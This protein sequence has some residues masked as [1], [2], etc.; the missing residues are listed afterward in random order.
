[1]KHTVTLRNGDQVPALGIGT[2]YLG[3]DRTKRKQELESLKE[4]V[5]A[6]MTLIDT[7]E[8]YGSGK[9]ELLVKEAMRDILKEMKREELYLVSKVLPNHAGKD[10]IETALD[11][12]LMRM[13]VEQLDLYLYHWRGSYPLEETVAEFER[14]KK[15]GKI[16]EWGVSNFDIDDMEELW[17]TPGGQ[18]C[19][20][21]QVLYHTG[22]R[23]IEYSLLPWMRE[24]EVALMSYCPLA[25]AGTLKRGLMTHP[26]LV[27][28]AEKYNAT[29]EQIMLAWNIRDGYTIAIPRS[30]KAEHTLQN[31]GA[32]LIT[33]SEEDYQA[34]DRAFPKPVRKEYL[35]MQ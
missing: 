33:L 22:S 23:G 28:L 19:L 18:N 30:G 10:R 13:G 29:V 12:T 17:E 8:M 5:H 32:D 20:V 7:A 26:V 6:G 15:A 35:D 31:A 24:H 25:Q 16:K 1:M 9:A 3:E 2:W 21:N 11:N 34:I 4:G 14:V 27:G